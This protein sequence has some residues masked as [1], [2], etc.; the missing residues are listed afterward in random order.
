M[1]L[2]LF[3]VLAGVGGMLLAAQKSYVVLTNWRPTRMTCAEFV[4]KRPSAKWVS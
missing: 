4:S 1:R 2:K 3:L